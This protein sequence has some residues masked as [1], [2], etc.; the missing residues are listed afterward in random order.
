METILF[1]VRDVIRR[2]GEPKN[3]EISFLEQR[4]FNPDT[5]GKAYQR[6]SAQAAQRDYFSG[7]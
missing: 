4:A 3:A 1:W 6:A 5:M 2:L 7:I